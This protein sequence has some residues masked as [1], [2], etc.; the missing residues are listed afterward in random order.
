M[1]SV[2]RAPKPKGYKTFIAK[3]GE[4]KAKWYVVDAANKSLGRISAPIAMRLMGKDKPTY[5]PH[6]D[7]GDF[8]IVINAEKVKIDPRKHLS[9]TY[10]HWSGYL[11]GMKIRTFEEVNQKA[12]ERII[13]HA[14]RL[15]LPKNLLAKRLITKLK[16]YKGT[17]HPHKAQQPVAWNPVG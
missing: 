11:G 17:D 3:P 8:V 16:V 1:Q 6:L 9:K 10:R 2:A 15:M 5:T 14:V 4:I 13:Q 12:P 7:T